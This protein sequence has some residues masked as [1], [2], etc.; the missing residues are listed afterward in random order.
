[1]KNTCF[2]LIYTYIDLIKGCLFAYK[3]KLIH[4]IMAEVEEKEKEGLQETP[5]VTPEVKETKSETVPEV[6]PNSEEVSPSPSDS[7]KE[8]E[9]P[10]V[11]GFRERI[12]ARG[13]KLYPEDITEDELDDEK[14]GGLVS[15]LLDDADGND[16]RIRILSEGN[17]KLFDIFSKDPDVFTVFQ[18]LK[19]GVPLPIALRKV[20]K[21]DYLTMDENDDNYKKYME[22]VRLK[23]ESDDKLAS[24]LSVSDSERKLYYEEAGM[25]EEEIKQ[26]ETAE[27]E[28]YKSMAEGRLDKGYFKRIHNALTHD[29]DVDSSYEQ[30]GVD[31]R[32]KKIKAIMKKEVGDGLPSSVNTGGKIPDKED[33]KEPE[34]LSFFKNM[35][36]KSNQSK[37]NQ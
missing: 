31:E 3:L 36:E 18:L 25:S 9:E 7:P 10:K 24:N 6:V 8:K 12:I 14:Y 26:F 5:P 4:L 13:K 32:N 28:L 27:N 17:K 34:E 35:A 19:D 2:S 29:N 22:E 16:E 15:R 21:E 30:G 11:V 1:M 23:R 33:V 20:Y 37:W